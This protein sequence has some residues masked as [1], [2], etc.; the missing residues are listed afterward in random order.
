VICEKRITYY[1]NKTDYPSAYS[2][3]IGLRRIFFDESCLQR[4]LC[5]AFCVM[6]FFIIKK[7]LI[8]SS[9][10]SICNALNFKFLALSTNSLV[11]K[12]I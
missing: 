10:S 7:K 11:V 9:L 8:K 4:I 5:H 2:P 3:K 12:M 6:N 1:V